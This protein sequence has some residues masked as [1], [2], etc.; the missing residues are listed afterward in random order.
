MQYVPDTPYVS[1]SLPDGD[2]LAQSMLMLSE[3]EI[4]SGIYFW[5]LELW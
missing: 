4:F 5:V 2:P 3:G 1:L